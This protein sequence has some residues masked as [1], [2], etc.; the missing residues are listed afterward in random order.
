MCTPSAVSASKS[1][2]S[3]A[4]NTPVWLDCLHKPRQRTAPDT[5]AK[6]A[7]LLSLSAGACK[8]YPVAP[9]AGSHAGSAGT[10]YSCGTPGTLDKHNLPPRNYRP[11][12]CF[13]Y[14]YGCT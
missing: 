9:A 3:E 7:V 2:V 8:S 4:Y 5:G 1:L 11:R 12:P 13:C 10:T 14:Q 6:F